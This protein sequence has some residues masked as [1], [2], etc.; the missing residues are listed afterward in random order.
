MK[1]TILVIT[2]LF[3]LTI[4]FLPVSANELTKNDINQ[5]IRTIKDDFDGDGTEDMVTL[6]QKNNE[7]LT[8]ANYD[9]EIS[10]KGKTFLIKDVLVGESQ[11]I[12]GLEKIAVSAKISPFI[13]ISYHC[14]AHSWGL[15]L[16]A[17]DGKQIKEIS[18]IGSDVPS[19][20]LKD[21]DND[22]ENEIIAEERDW[23]SDNSVQD[24]IIETYKYNA[25]KWELIS[26]YET[27]TKKF[28]PINT[29]P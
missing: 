4:N 13:G 9:L 8:F 3:C 24:R 2:F 12:R 16:Y 18:N 20:Q 27:R 7:D 1:A 5:S 6:K 15:D 17:F 29:K 22:G 19:I 28:L 21:V 25:K 11:N 14:G 23:D 26:K 10:S